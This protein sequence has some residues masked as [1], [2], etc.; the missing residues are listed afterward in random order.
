[1]NK[2]E[3]IRVK[4]GFVVSEVSDKNA[5]SVSVAEDD[6]TLQIIVRNWANGV[7]GGGKQDGS[8]SSPNRASEKE[9]G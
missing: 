7:L 5:E 3:I 9:N 4:N 2:I 6:V 8:E 1:M